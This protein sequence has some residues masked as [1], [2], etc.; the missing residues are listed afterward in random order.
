[1]ALQSKDLVHVCITIKTSGDSPIAAMVKTPLGTIPCIFR[2]LRLRKNFACELLPPLRT[3][4]L[5]AL[6]FVQAHFRTTPPF[7]SPS[8][9]AFPTSPHPR[10]PKDGALPEESAR[11][12]TNASPAPQ[13]LR[14]I[15]D[16]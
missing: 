3:T 15:P 13:M 8:S 7:H 9:L 1:M 11:T 16:L 2:V 6:R 10:R 12:R 5:K 4:C 14:N